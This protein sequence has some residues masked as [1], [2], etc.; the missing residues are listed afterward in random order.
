MEKWILPSSLLALVVLGFWT[1]RHRHGDIWLLLGVTALVA[2]LWAHHRWYDDLLILLPMVALFRVAKR[3]PSAEGDDVV[4][5][6]LLGITTL[7]MLAPG[8]LYLFPPPWNGLYVAGQV[9][10]WVVVLIFLLDRARR[11]NATQAA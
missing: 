4:A 3:A 9:I 2:R 7:A 8:G 6:L 11:K 1:Y 10:V 5:G